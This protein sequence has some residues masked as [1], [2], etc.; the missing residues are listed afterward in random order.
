MCGLAV[1]DP[2]PADI[3]EDREFRTPR[4]KTMQ[5]YRTVL[6]VPMI[7]GLEARKATMPTKPMLRSSRQSAG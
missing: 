4:V 5:D 3:R 1:L 6:A 2:F 7:K